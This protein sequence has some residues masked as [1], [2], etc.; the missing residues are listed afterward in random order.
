MSAAV[1]TTQLQDCERCSF[2]VWFF[3]GEH[4]MNFSS[5]NRV[6]AYARQALYGTLVLLG[7][8]QALA[9]EQPQQLQEVT[10]TAQR[11]EQNIQNV[12]IAITAFTSEALVDRNLTDIHALSNLTSGV[13]L[14]AGAP[15]SGDRSVLSASIRGI[16]QDDFA[17]NLNPGVGVYLDGV[18]L[19]RTI[20]ANQTL[21]D[22]DRIEVLKGPQGTLF[23]ANTIGGAI[24][25]VTHT[26]G[27][28]PQ[29]IAQAT[30]GEYNL[31][32]V[33]FTADIPIIPG[34]LLSTITASSQNQDGWV[35]VIPYPTS[36]PQ[37][38]TPFVVDPQTAYPK[39]GYTTGDDYGGTGVTTIR[40]KMLW[41]A[42]D[43]LN[44]T[45][46]GDWTHEDQTALPY[47]IL[48]V[49]SGNLNT[50]TFSTLYNLCI[51]NNAASLPG[52][53]AAV[54]GPPPFVQPVNSFFVGMCTNPRAQVPGLSTGGAPLLGAGYVGGPVGP[55]NAGNTGGVPYLGSSSPRLWFDYAATNTGHLNSTYA[56]G[57]DFARNDAF[58]GSVTAVY[59]L[60]N[61]LTLKSITGYRQIKWNIGTDLDGTP[62]TLQEVTDAQHQWQVSQEVQL[63]GKALDNKLNYVGGLYYFKEAGYVHDYVPFESLL[64]VYDISNNVE[65]QNYAAFLH[66]DYQLTEALGF[67][68]GGRYTEWKTNFLGGQSDLNNFPSGIG[69]YTLY[70]PA[71]SRV[72]SPI[73]RT[74]RP[75]TSSRR[76]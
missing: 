27:D 42:S 16:G 3:E 49:Y 18:Y 13:N 59:D 17:F 26:P 44:V 47:T 15:F 8:A 30:G 29:F 19:A 60:G 62:E 56:N 70:G 61:E 63:L 4:N 31:R 41:K 72:T 5:A 7:C 68:A 48:G 54:G 65:N 66:L 53:I 23:G 2:L 11:R 58:G 45:F 57:P 12:P 64:Y 74:A 20:G 28:T 10:V 67:T 55:Y 50:S 36:S 43:K 46:T 51:S 1:T 33:A 35:K 73:F 69:N 14:D 75:G 34:V 25:I 24:S 32:D 76:A 6:R 22:V 21:L 38:A 71:T 9:Q 52:A 37:G 40:G 39:A